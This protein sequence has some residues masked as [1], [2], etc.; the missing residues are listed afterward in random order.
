M[1]KIS[2][3]VE[4]RLSAGIQKFQPILRRAQL[5]GRN[6]SDTVTIITDI[7]CEVFGYDKYEEITSELCIKQQ[8]CDIAV[9]LHG[10][11]RLLMEC[12]AVGVALREGHVLQA[13]SYAANSGIDWVVLTNGIT[14]RIYQV[15]FG[16]PV[17]TVLVCEFN[18]CDLNVNQPEDYA[19]LYALCAEAFQGEDNTALSQLYVQ[20]RV[21][22]RYVVGQV[23]LNDWMIGTIRRSL[24][25]HYPG[26]KMDDGDVRRILREEVLRSEI[27]EGPQAEDARQDVEAANAR[28][29]AAQKGRRS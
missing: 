4:T 5:A 10:K 12:K 16:K 19:P 8:F 3:P 27:V 14:W 18:F 17:E 24:E 23:L 21:L 7:L 2:A 11:V 22:N 1:Q 26:V 15:L 6:E 20:R 13:S 25:R 9:R 28:M 29:R